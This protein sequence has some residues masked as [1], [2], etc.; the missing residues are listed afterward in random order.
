MGVGL[1]LLVGYSLQLGAAP[2]E[3][4][5]YTV[6]ILVIAF[7]E[8]AKLLFPGLQSPSRWFS[9]LIVIGITLKGAG[10]NW[11]VGILIPFLHAI[12]HYGVLRILQN[13]VTYGEGILISVL[14]SVALFDFIL[15]CAH[16]VFT[17]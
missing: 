16:S 17:I 15:I 6:G 10:M 4:S 13:S 12:I 5:E 9:S 11:S 14:G 8:C 7:L 2:S 1:P 3:Y